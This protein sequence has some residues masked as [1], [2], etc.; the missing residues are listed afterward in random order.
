MKIKQSFVF[1]RRTACRLG[2][3]SK[4]YLNNHKCVIS[5]SVSVPGCL[6]S[7]FHEANDIVKILDLSLSHFLFCSVF[8]S[9]SFSP[10]PQN[11]SLLP[12]IL[13]LSFASCHTHFCSPGFQNEGKCSQRYVSDLPTKEPQKGHNARGHMITGQTHKKSI[14]HGGLSAVLL[15]SWQVLQTEDHGIV[16]LQTAQNPVSNSG[17]N[18][19]THDIL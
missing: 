15:S 5:S 17:L 13:S 4:K 16:R 14:K 19:L 11:F 12:H 10:H 7:Q 2:K 3:P 18:H 8:L 6:R 1:Q 9:P